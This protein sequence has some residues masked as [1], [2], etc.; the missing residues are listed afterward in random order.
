[1]AAAGLLIGG[2]TFF[3]TTRDGGRAMASGSG[4]ERADPAFVSVI[5]GDTFV[6]RSERIR[7]ADIDAPEV[8]GRCAFETNLAAQA[9]ARMRA[10]LFQGPFELHLLAS[11]RDRDVYGRQLRI[12]TRNGRSLGDQLVAEGLARTWTGYREPWC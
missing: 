5:D 9:T 10:L 11:G 4:T 8:H 7:I 1:M 12:V 2:V 3:A 6:Y